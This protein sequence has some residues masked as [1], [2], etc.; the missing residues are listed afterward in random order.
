MDLICRTSARASDSQKTDFD[1]SYHLSKTAEK[2]STGYAGTPRNSSAIL[3]I[4]L[5]MA[6]VYPAESAIFLLAAICYL[7]CGNDLVV[8]Q[9]RCDCT[10]SVSQ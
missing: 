2:V 3:P 10:I 6:K 4:S 8:Y 7:F 9:G 1:Q 5:A